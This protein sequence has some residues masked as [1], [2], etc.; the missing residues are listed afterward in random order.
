MAHNPVN[1]PAR[2]AYRAVGGLTGLYLVIF[3]V[4]GLVR[5][6][7][8][9]FFAR[10]DVLVLGQGVNRGSAVLLAVLGAII[11]IGT[12]I[13]RNV[14]VT[15]NRLLGYLFM[16]LGLVSLTLLRTEA[17]VLDFS[18]VTCV[19]V[20]VLGMVLML[21]GMYGRI[22]SAEEAKAWQVGRLGL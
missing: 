6:D 8:A 12:V 4:L 17:N 16:I 7:S 15:V 3:G 22:G 9:D 20:M 1:H 18:V 13:G 5:D 14:D 11:L 21:A 19:V 10:D 2:P